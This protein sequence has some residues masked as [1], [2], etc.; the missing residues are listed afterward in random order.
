MR[1]LDF[2]K[3]ILFLFFVCAI[4]IW[5]GFYSIQYQLKEELI[6]KNDICK[7]KYK[8]LP[9]MEQASILK[10]FDVSFDRKSVYL[11]KVENEYYLGVDKCT[12]YYFDY[13]TPQHR[14]TYKH[15]ISI[16][17]SPYLSKKNAKKDL[18]KN[19]NHDYSTNGFRRSNVV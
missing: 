11:G 19:S 3:I 1:M 17:Y 13:D 2:S 5:I 8:Y 10:Y 6:C 4:F 16:F 15:K 9:N 18:Q 14:D 7:I 12:Y